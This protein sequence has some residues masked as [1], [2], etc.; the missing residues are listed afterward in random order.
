[1]ELGEGGGCDP[2]SYTLFTRSSPLS[3]NQ[4][5]V[6]NVVL[7]STNL[8]V[9]I[10][11]FIW[12]GPRDHSP[13]RAGFIPIGMCQTVTRR[14]RPGLACILIPLLTHPRLAWRKILSFS[15]LDN[16]KYARQASYAS[17]RV[18]Q[19]DC[20]STYSTCHKLIFLSWFH[21]FQRCDYA[22]LSILTNRRIFSFFFTTTL[23]EAFLAI[24][25]LRQM[26]TTVRP[27]SILHRSSFLFHR[28]GAG[29]IFCV[30]WS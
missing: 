7:P 30:V 6:A 12:A 16:Q 2:W 27:G 23:Y 20:P 17:T 1:M 28:L 11:V 24:R 13:S 29:E 3:P 19:C 22:Q 8:H 14:L 26:E 18:R 10:L 4:R 9:R 25:H 21:H 5:E 15:S